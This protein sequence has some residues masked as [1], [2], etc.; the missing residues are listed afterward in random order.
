MSQPKPIQL[1]LC[2][3]NMTLK[4]KSIYSSR[5]IIMR[6]IHERCIQ[7]LKRRVLLNLQ[8]LQSMIQWNEQMG[9]RVFRLSSELFLIKPIP[10]SNRI[11]LSLLYRCYNR[12]VH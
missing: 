5:K 9:I 10:K 8:D 6:I 12:L 4:Q 11:V 7:E 3:Q 2:C 1:G